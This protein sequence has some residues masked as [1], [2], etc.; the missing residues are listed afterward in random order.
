MYFLGLV[1]DIRNLQT[2]PQLALTLGGAEPCG[3]FAVRKS[4]VSVCCYHHHGGAGWV[5]PSNT[6]LL[7]LDT[8]QSTRE[9]HDSRVLREQN[10]QIPDIRYQTTFILQK[11]IFD[12][13][14]R[15]LSQEW[16]Q[17]QHGLQPEFREP[18][19]LLQWECSHAEGRSASSPSALPYC[20]RNVKGKLSK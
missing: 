4:C 3:I 12:K 2:D 14:I 20:P 8:R 10:L 1:I 15:M 9:K 11:L 17:S 18:V 6:V 16:R 19:G 5:L 7:T 13:F